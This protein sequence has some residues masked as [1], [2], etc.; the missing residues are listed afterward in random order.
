MLR[1]CLTIS[2]LALETAP[3]NTRTALRTTILPIGGGS[4][5]ESPVLVPKGTAVAYSVYTVHRRRD[6]YG[7]DTELFR[8]ERWDEDMPLNPRRDECRIGIPAFQ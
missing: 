3:G 6:L 2:K 1:S 7:M 5:R 8:P 4:D